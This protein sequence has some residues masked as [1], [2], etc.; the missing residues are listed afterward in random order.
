MRKIVAVL[1]SLILLLGVVAS[2]EVNPQTV[3]RSGALAG[4][5]SAVEAHTR[6]L[7]GQLVLVDIRSTDEWRETGVPASGYTITMHQD[8]AMFMRQLAEATGGSRE[9]P[10]ALICAVGSRSAFLQGRLKQ[11]GFENVIDV[12]EGVIGG[13]RGTGWI[14][15]G[16]P[17]RRWLP[18]LD[19]PESHSN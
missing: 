11:A 19:T 12:G 7:A 16:L 4:V 18:G 14:K 6:A 9:K 8:R 5:M 13:R 1:L 10:I 3:E 17:L 15:S 2:A